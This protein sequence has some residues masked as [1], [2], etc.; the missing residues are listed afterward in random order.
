[1]TSIPIKRVSSTTDETAPWDGVVFIYEVGSDELNE[2]LRACFPNYRTLRQRKHAAIIKF[3]ER[4][5]S[6]MPMT[7]TSRSSAGTPSAQDL[8]HTGSGCVGVHVNAQKSVQ[9]QSMLSTIHSPATSNGPLAAQEKSKR[10]IASST[11]AAQPLYIDPT[12]ATHSS[13]FVFN[14]LDGRAMQQKTKRRMTIEERMEYKETRKRGA[15]PRCKRQKGKYD[16]STQEVGSL[17]TRM[18]RAERWHRMVPLS[19]GTPD[20]KSSTPPLLHYTVDD[21][22]RDS[23]TSQL[24]DL[25]QQQ[26]SHG[27]RRS[28]CASR[29]SLSGSVSP[30]LSNT[31]N[32]APQSGMFGYV[33]QSNSSEQVPNFI[34]DDPA[35][36]WTN[37]CPDNLDSYHDFNSF[38]SEAAFEISRDKPEYP[39]CPAIRVHEPDSNTHGPLDH[40]S[41]NQW[42]L[43]QHT[44]P[45]G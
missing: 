7:K 31:D 44:H 22:R 27:S 1:M 40:S 43:G 26:P 19:L 20:T 38:Q 13:Q 35:S 23:V 37:Y 15:C 14:A 12:A 16:R 25:Q 36:Y 4:E 8:P 45:A 42:V 28:S 9:S 21:D 5:L 24:Y 11:P 6:E 3:L 39:G 2:A 10:C 29:P 33:Q 18:H 41:F 34:S 32:L 30:R 17:Q